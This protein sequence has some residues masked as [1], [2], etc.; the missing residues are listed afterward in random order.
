ME[1][2]S[3]LPGGTKGVCRNVAAVSSLQSGDR[4]RRTIT[5]LQAWALS[6][7]TSIGWGS[8]VITSNTYLMNAGPVGSALGMIVGALVMLIIAEN[9]YGLMCRYPESG[10]VYSYVK[11]VFG[12]GDGFLVAW[13]LSLTYLAILWANAT[14]L[15]LFARYFL[16]DIFRVGRL[17]TL[18]GYD[19][20]LGEALLSTLAM[21]AFALLIMRRSG[22]ALR[23]N[24]VL[25]LVFTL[26]ITLCFFGVLLRGGAKEGFEP[27]F[28]PDAGVLQQVARIA[29]ISPW[30]FIGFEN[31]TH[32][33]EEFSFPVKHAFVECEAD[34][35]RRI[36]EKSIQA[37]GVIVGDLNG[38][39][40]VNDTLGHRAGDEFIRSGCMMICRCFKSSPVFRIGGDEFAVI[41]EGADYERRQELL[42]SLN[43]CMVQNIGTGS[44]VAALGMAEF[45][46]DEDHSFRS[47]F[48]RA[49]QHMY[50]HKKELKALGADVRD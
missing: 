17:Y 10:G 35:D 8:F 16:G 4:L 50:E 48:E 33:A 41:L 11:N 19:V 15:P 24:A 9:Y 23:I 18:F 37:F 46:P 6:I 40:T 28:V 32:A 14:S 5:P 13:F 38:T 47:V 21:L 44:P 43:A 39:K 7:G 3:R 31:I 26:G 30:A 20:F 42:D 27:R 2:N 1:N 49:D 34:F 36:D 29:F 25:A 45:R 12:H 22:L